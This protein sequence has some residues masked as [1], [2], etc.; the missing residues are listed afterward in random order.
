MAATRELPDTLWQHVAR[1]Q[2]PGGDRRRID[3][4]TRAAMPPR[5]GDGPV[6]R[7]V[8]PFDV[9]RALEEMGGGGEPSV[10]TKARDRVLWQ[11][12]NG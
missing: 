3:E 11:E 6:R 8:L 12:L 9:C 1:G 10:W 5:F 2:S 7:Q 4:A